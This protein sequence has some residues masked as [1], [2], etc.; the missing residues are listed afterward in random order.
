MM[1]CQFGLKLRRTQQS[2]NGRRLFGR[3]EFL[4]KNRLAGFNAILYFFFYF[5]NWLKI[6]IMELLEVEKMK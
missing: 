2:S 3:G 4:K 1:N 5:G 6:F